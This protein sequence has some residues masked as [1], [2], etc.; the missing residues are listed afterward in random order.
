MNA[1]TKRVLPLRAA[2]LLLG[3]IPVGAGAAQSSVPMELPPP[4]ELPEFTDSI[5]VSKA[6]LLALSNCKW[7]VES[8]T[9]ESITA[10]LDIRRHTAR[11]RLDYTPRRIRY[12]YLDSAELGYEIEDGEPLI[13][14]AFNKWLQQ[15]DQ[16]IRI[17]TQRFYFEREPVDVVPGTPA[18]AQ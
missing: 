2:L 17:Q 13:H 12:H 4:L 1:G 6:L 14:P 10:R 15:L 9:G 5:K 18:P 11:I 16:E 8:D 7:L 3:L